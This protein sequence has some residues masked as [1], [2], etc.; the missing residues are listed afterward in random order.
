MATKQFSS[1]PKDSNSVGNIIAKLIADNKPPSFSCYLISVPSLL[2]SLA[3]QHGLGPS[4]QA[5]YP[6][7]LE[8]YYPSLEGH[9]PFASEIVPEWEKYHSNTSIRLWPFVTLPYVE[10]LNH[11]ATAKGNL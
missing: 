6:P 3:Q 8:P 7:F 11:I 9:L 10:W 2:T 4:F 1:T 5:S